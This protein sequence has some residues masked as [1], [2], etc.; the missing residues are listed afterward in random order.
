MPYKRLRLSVWKLR[1]EIEAA[2][3]SK[4]IRTAKSYRPKR[5]LRTQMNEQ[6]P[7][8]RH[9]RATRKGCHCAVNIPW[10]PTCIHRP[11]DRWQLPVPAIS[12]KLWLRRADDSAHRIRCDGPVSAV[13]H[14]RA[15][16]SS[17]AVTPR[18]PRASAARVEPARCCL[19]SHTTAIHRNRIHA[20]RFELHLN[21]T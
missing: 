15:R 14:W 1:N 5:P 17:N 16:S 11:C 4:W 3:R 7:P 9:P 8:C 10:Q 13:G 20:K 12:D 18:N 21:Q 6:V 2:R 19:E